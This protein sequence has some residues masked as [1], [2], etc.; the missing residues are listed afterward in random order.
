MWKKKVCVLIIVYK[1]SLEM[2]K[3]VIRSFNSKKNR[4]R[5]S[6]KKLTARQN[7]SQKKLQV[8]SHKLH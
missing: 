8:G 2:Q 6:Q 4:Q 5:N 3:G 1:K 7:T